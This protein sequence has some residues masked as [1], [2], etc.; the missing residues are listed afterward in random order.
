M[1]A[2]LAKILQAQQHLVR[3]DAQAALSIVQPLAAKHPSEPDVISFMS[4]IL[5]RQQKHTQ[6]AFYAQR[7]AQLRPNDANYHSN[8]ALILIAAGKPDKAAAAYARC[9]EL[10]PAHPEARLGLANQCLS[11]RNTTGAMRHCEAVLKA[12]WNPQVSLTYAGA[13]TGS[14][15]VERANAFTREALT[16]FPND[17]GLLHGLCAGLNYSHTAAP[18]EIAAVHRAYG[19]AVLLQRPNESF[20]LSREPLVDPAGKQRPLRVGFISHDLRSHSVSYF[21]EPFFE[22]HDRTSV[23]VFAYSTTHQPDAVSQRLK[24]HIPAAWRDCATLTDL[25][26]S[27]R[28]EQ[29][30][31]DVLID[32]GGHT[33]NSLLTVFAF[34]PAPVQATY[35][36]YPNTTGIP[37]MDWRIVDSQTDPLPADPPSIAARSA[38]QPNFDERCTEELWR[39]DPCFLCYRP[40]S[41]EDAPAPKARTG[42]AAPLFGS[43]NANKKIGPHTIALWAKILH[44]VPDSR[45]LLKTFELKDPAAKQRILDRFSAEGIEPLRLEV[46]PATATITEHLALYDRVDV[47]LDTLP[48]NGTTTTCEALWMGVPVISVSGA[49]HAARV[50]VSLLTTIG[51]PELIAPDEEAYIRLAADL[52]RDS[53]RLAR[54]RA[55]LRGMI[56]A[57]ALCDAPAFAKRFGD[58][59]RTMFEQRPVKV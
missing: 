25:Q 53:A 30:K 21:I 16:H 20:N 29:D 43:F 5:H 57:S 45:M 19:E 49:V 56:R 58:A 36:G 12:G 15:D 1:S 41:P 47:A 46:L 52:A 17:V 31:I 32:L 28:I 2:L 51:A 11:D 35:C 55:D 39:L 23:E 48:Y 7:A 40:P 59:L 18:A 26:T 34:K 14:G 24:S 50:G 37:T 27:R 38:G 42:N 22:L 4:I 13:L 10:N 54:Y 8:L 33:L 9:I 44:R 6:A 3:G